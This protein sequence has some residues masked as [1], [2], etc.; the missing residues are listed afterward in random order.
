MDLIGESWEDYKERLEAESTFQDMTLEEME[1]GVEG[2][3]EAILV[4]M[5]EIKNA[6]D[7]SAAVEYFRLD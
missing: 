3:K 7:M 6:T 1:K 2:Y 4:N 5:E